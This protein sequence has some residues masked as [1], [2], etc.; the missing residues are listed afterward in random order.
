MGGIRTS[1]SNVRAVLYKHNPSITGVSRTEQGDNRRS[2][3][4]CNPRTEKEALQ[5]LSGIKTD[6]QKIEF[7]EV[8]T[9]K[10]KQ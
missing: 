2:K 3:R 1:A 9:R 6:K 7:V 4:N 8:Q 10:E 5:E